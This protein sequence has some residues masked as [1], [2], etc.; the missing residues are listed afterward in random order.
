MS[1]RLYMAEFLIRTSRYF[2]RIGEFLKTLTVAVL[3]PADMAEWA[4]KRYNRHS[5]LFN[6][7][8]DPNQG[9]TDDERVL[10]EHAPSMVPARMLILGGGG[11]REA[12]FFGSNGWKVTALD[13]SEGMLEQASSA[14]G[15]CGLDLK[16][17]QGDLATFDSSAGSFEAVWTS[18]FLYSLVL[19]RACRV[20]M[21]RRIQRMLTPGG[22]FIVSF[23]F[24]SQISM[25]SKADQIRKL[26]ARMTFGNVEYQ[27]G[28]ILFGTIEFRHVFSSESELRDEFTEAGFK[29]LNF[30]IFNGLMRG[31]AVLSVQNEC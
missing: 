17:V 30:F 23:H 6:E 12:I 26:I 18:M 13:I 25:H 7:E 22:W 21:L 16:T 11:G 5:T 19:G 20:A 15:S 4:R 2:L 8:N 3:S 28:D 27:K 14:A 1:A 31:G 24:D 10:W 29:I 9:L